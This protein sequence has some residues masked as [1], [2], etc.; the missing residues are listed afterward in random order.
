MLV[1]TDV[2]K[3]IKTNAD[4]VRNMTDEMLVDFIVKPCKVI[5]K[6]IHHCAFF[7]DEC[8]ED[9]LKERVEN[10]EETNKNLLSKMV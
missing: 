6:D 10:Y 8:I 4:R 5:K 9:W 7:C 2:D 3:N 1:I